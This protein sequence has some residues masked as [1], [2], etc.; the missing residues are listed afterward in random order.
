MSTKTKK[1][2]IAFGAELRRR[3]EARGHTLRDFARQLGISATYLSEVERGR[4]PG[5]LSTERI[6]DAARLLHEDPDEWLVLAGKTA[7]GLVIYRRP[8]CDLKQLWLMRTLRDFDADE[9]ERV[10]DFVAAIKRRKADKRTNGG[11]PG[12]DQPQAGLGAPASPVAGGQ[13][14]GDAET[15]EAGLITSLCLLI[16]AGCAGWITWLSL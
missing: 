16:A 14:R 2:L 1:E 6:I 9:Y 11:A 3:R 12:P 10:L 8:G 13:G 4:L 5:T 15:K 7:A